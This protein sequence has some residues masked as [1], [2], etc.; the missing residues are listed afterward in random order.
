MTETT[1]ETVAEISC[2]RVSKTSFKQW[3]LYGPVDQALKT[4]TQA[5]A[6]KVI[7]IKL[8]VHGEEVEVE[9]WINA[10]PA[11]PFSDDELN[12]PAQ[13]ILQQRELAEKGLNRTEEYLAGNDLPELPLVKGVGV[14]TGPGAT[15]FPQQHIECT[16]AALVGQRPDQEAG[17][18]N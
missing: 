7:P 8:E 3:K 4:S 5:A 6:V 13:V 2:V 11:T 10:D 12:P 15:E 16:L 14:L 17:T 9:L 1:N 18:E